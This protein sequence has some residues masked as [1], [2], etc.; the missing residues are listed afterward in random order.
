MESSWYLHW[1]AHWIDIY[2]TLCKTLNCKWK[3]CGLNWF[4]LFIYLYVWFLNNKFVIRRN[5]III[6]VKVKQNICLMLLFYYYF[7]AITTIRPSLAWW[8]NE[9][10]KRNNKLT[11][12]QHKV[13][14]SYACAKRETTAKRFIMILLAKKGKGAKALTIYNYMAS[15]LLTWGLWIVKHNYNWFN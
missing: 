12:Q 15:S 14:Y 9:K 5:Y 6:F 8:K 3:S 13:S 10:K 11:R 1:R 2:C 7:C 4:Y